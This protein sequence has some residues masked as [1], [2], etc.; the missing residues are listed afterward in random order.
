[1]IRLLLAIFAI[2]LS[3]QAVAQGTQQAPEP[4][5]EVTFE[6]T[7]TIPG[8]TLSLRLTVLVP[9]YMPEPPV[10]PS[11]EAPNLL[12]RL[13]GR[14]TNATSNQ[15]SGQTW[16]GVSRR[17]L[18]TPMVPGRLSIPA[19]DVIVT[20]ADPATNKP[21]K[22][23]L[24][25]VPLTVFAVVP[26]AAKELDPFIA[27]E[28]LE[29]TQDISGETTNLRPGDSFSWVIKATVNGISPMFLPSLAPPVEFESVDAYADEPFVEEIDNAG[30]IGGSR[31]ERMTFV[32][33]SGGQV[34][35]PSVSLSWYNLLSGKV[36]EARLDGFAIDVIGAHTGGKTSQIIGIFLTAI[37][38]FTLFGGLLYWFGIRP[39]ERAIFGWF[40]RQHQRWRRSEIWAYRQLRTAIASRDYAAFCMALDAWVSKTSAPDP[41]RNSEFRR[42]LVRI[43]EARYGKSGKMA[44]SDQEWRKLRELLAKLRRASGQAHKHARGLGALNPS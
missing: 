37:A 41:R 4:I 30:V 15:I 36:E 29:L 26:K 38:A 39:W 13:V 10:W 34:L 1:M 35:V 33:T 21:V 6:H 43:G 3:T 25:I 44:I 16:S 27:A 9:T 40:R 11:L 28:R 5:L 32:A 18:I 42:L 8:Q 22:A 20:Y 31:L 23:N 2:V 24:K 19:N 14:S 7:E 12:V 17:Y